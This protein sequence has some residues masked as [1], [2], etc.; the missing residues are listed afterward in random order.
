[1]DDFSISSR[2]NA[3]ASVSDSGR[4]SPLSWEKDGQPPKPKPRP[5]RPDRDGQDNSGEED[6]RHGLDEEA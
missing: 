4:R 6:P 3:P 5:R 2:L 1:M